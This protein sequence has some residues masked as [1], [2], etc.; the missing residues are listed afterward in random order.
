MTT[1]D[2]F[3]KPATEAPKRTPEEVAA[4]ILDTQEVVRFGSD[5]VRAAMDLPP[6]READPK[7]LVRALDIVCENFH[8]ELPA[9]VKD[10]L[11]RAPYEK[12]SFFASARGEDL[13]PRMV[14]INPAPEVR[15]FIVKGEE[16]RDGE[17]GFVQLLYDFRV[18]PGRPLPD[19]SIDFRD[20]NKFPQAQEG[21]FL[22]RVYEPTE[23]KPGTDVYG[24]PIPARPGT[25][26]DLKVGDG[27]HVEREFDADLERPFRLLSA[28]KSGIIVAEFSGEKRDAASLKALS[29]Q[30]QI[31]VK[32]VDFSTGNLGD[33]LDEIR[34]LAD[35]VVEGDIRGSF[36]VLVEGALEVKGAIEGE[37]V[38]A[39][40]PITAS[41]IRSSARSGATIQTGAAVNAR[42]LA[43]EAV[44]VGRE[45]AGCR[46][47]APRF[48]TS[49][50]GVA[51]VLCGHVH[52]VARKVRM[53]KAA[54]RNEV[55]LDLGT[56]LF[57][58]LD[59]LAEREADI[60]LRK[61]AESRNLKDRVK[62]LA[63]K[64]KFAQVAL[65]PEDQPALQQLRGM[66]VAVLRGQ[67]ALD[68]ARRGLEA[69]VQEAVPSLYRMGKWVRQILAILGNMV[70]LEAQRAEIA[71]MREAVVEELR[72]LSVDVEGTVWSGG[73]VVIRCGTLEEVVQPP[74]EVAKE[75]VEIHLVYDPDVKRLVEAF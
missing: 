36:V 25:P 67:M 46:V 72:G 32:D 4:W 39:S 47:V 28:A 14:D 16:P 5:V 11:Q 19:G 21:E 59:D 34:C 31:V 63:N 22:V 42:L 60:R 58:R 56:E 57:A 64:L 40:G 7:T 69:W 74:P 18:R 43:E 75:K 6:W 45:V 8:I 48:E 52:V 66:L 29:L 27:I 1:D 55:V 17:D 23:G 65:D 70:Q 12:V 38:E 30:N 73:R 61:E 35:V 26:C 33:R 54:I 15:T 68:D 13:L 20:I 44:V 9:E 62:V 71:G 2:I 51:E 41:F 10:S 37:N 24:L 50:Q 3:Q 53:E 49:P